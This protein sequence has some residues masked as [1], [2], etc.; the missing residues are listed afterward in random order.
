MFLNEEKPIDNILKDDCTV[1]SDPCTEQTISKQ[2][3]FPMEKI[4][5]HQRMNR[6]L[7]GGRDGMLEQGIPE[8]PGKPQ[9]LELQELRGILTRVVGP[10]AK[11]PKRLLRNILFP[12]D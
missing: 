3:I 12:I 8:A 2:R 10:L 5:F 1:G 9:A 7:S 11:T 6:C 4:L